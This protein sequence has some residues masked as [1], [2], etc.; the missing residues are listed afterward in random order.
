MEQTLGVVTETD[1]GYQLA[2]ERTFKHPPAKVWRA[3]TDP[4]ELRNWFP[5][6]VDFDVTVGAKLTFAPTDKQRAKF[7]LTDADA[8]QGELIA[9]DPPKLLEYTWGEDRLRWQLHDTADG[10]CRLEFTQT[11]P[12]RDSAIVQGAG[13][14]VGFEQIEALLDG[15]TPAYD[16][17]ERATELAATYVQAHTP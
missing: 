6:V 10:G 7:G 4:G 13:W 15:T 17:F 14:H 5:A 3:L 2:F 8:A 1:G 12:E 9:A 16:P 11:C